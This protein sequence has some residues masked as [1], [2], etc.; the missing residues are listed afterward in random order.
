MNLNKQSLLRISR[1][2]TIAVAA[3]LTIMALVALASRHKGPAQLDALLDR[4]SPAENAGQQE[5]P[6]NK[7]KDK[8]TDKDK[9]PAPDP[10]IE[11]IT[12]RNF[13][14][15]PKKPN[16]F[17]VKLVG[18]L[19]DQ[20]YFE[21]ENKGIEV[22]QSFKGA[23]LKIIGPDWVEFEFE[24]KPKKFYVFGQDKGGPPKPPGMPGPGRPGMPRPQTPP[25]AG[26]R[27]MPGNIKLTPERIERFKS[28]PPEVRQKVLESMPANLR[29]QIE[30]EL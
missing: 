30:K 27:P 21:G 11:R 19:G 29:E 23:T 18:V 3:L 26:S 15:P 22:D 24:G 17:S 5:D 14:G 16:G 20:A 9:K 7:D 6:N 1:L 12:K 25:S 13:F 8:K 28:M 2:T 10:R 4:Y